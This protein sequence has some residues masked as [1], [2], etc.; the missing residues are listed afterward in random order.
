V[1]IVPEIMFPG[2]TRSSSSCMIAINRSVTEVCAVEAIF[3]ITSRPTQQCHIGSRDRDSEASLVA[4]AHA[5][6]VLITSGNF[7]IVCGGFSPN[8]RDIKIINT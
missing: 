6:K 5:L 2:R 4:V 1:S 8:L 3:P 7:Q